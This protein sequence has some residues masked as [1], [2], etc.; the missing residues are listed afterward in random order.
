MSWRKP[1]VRENSAMAACPVLHNYPSAL[2]S[3]FASHIV[4]QQRHSPQRATGIRPSGPRPRV[5]RNSS[6][7]SSGD[8]SEEK[9][10]PSVSKKEP[11]AL[12]TP[13]PIKHSSA[14]VARQSFT[15]NR[16][17]TKAG[18]KSTSEINRSNALE[19]ALSRCAAMHYALSQHLGGM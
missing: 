12:P 7:E 4:Q 2:R 9:D 8:T 1:R 14:F 5:V 6:S 13:V 15:Q 11:V 17:P 19:S 3:S 16:K 10:A 18:G